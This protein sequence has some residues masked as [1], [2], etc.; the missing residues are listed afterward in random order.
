MS[1]SELVGRGAELAALGAALDRAARAQPTAVA[2]VGEPGIGK[3]CLLT[4]LGRQ[5]DARDMLVLTGGAS[6]F[7]SD[8]PFWIFVDAFD[9]Y[10]RPSAAA[11]RSPRRRRPRGARARPADVVSDGRAAPLAGRSALPHPRRDA[12]PPGAARSAPVVLLLDDLHW[13]DSG[14]VELLCALLRR[15]PT[16]PVLIG[17]A[18]RPRQ[19]PSR[20]AAGLAGRPGWS[21]TA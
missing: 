3:T 13:A 9:E 1:E 4:E 2:L 14:S 6:E 19:V 7:E 15:P 8:M 12:P 17:M 21:S 16:A 18:F 11:A 10:L 20:L 5:A